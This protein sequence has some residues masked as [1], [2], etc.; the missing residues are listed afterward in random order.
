MKILCIIDSLRSGGAQRQLVNLAKGFKERGHEVSFLVYHPHDF[1]NDELE[2]SDIKITCILEPSYIKRLIRMRRFIR[3][4]NFDSVLSFLEAANFIATVSGFPYRR[5]KLVVGERSANPNI[6]K[7]FKLR[8]YR[9]FHV[10]ADYI[11]SNSESNMN[12]VIKANPLLRDKKKRVIYNMLNIS[13][14]FVGDWG[15]NKKKP[16]IFRL[17]IG[18]SHSK[19]K[20]LDGLVEA[21]NLLPLDKKRQLKVDW[22]GEKDLDESLYMAK[23]KINKYQMTDIFTFYDPTPFLYAKM[24]EADGC[25]LFSFY[26]GFPNFICEAMVLGK[27]IICTKVSD[28]PLLLKN[29]TNAFFCNASDPA[30]ISNAIMNIMEMTKDEYDKMIKYN[31]EIASKKFDKEFIIDS[32]LNLLNKK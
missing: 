7:S 5:W 4:G 21:V 11:V 6:L 18:A 20:N 28:L 3:K 31:K 16:S 30:S 19:L 17:I 24:K 15:V 10:F 8:F 23:I 22:Y 25:G 32:Y 27:P 29:N 26:E 13:N 9:W 12:L 14:N 1:Y 2:H